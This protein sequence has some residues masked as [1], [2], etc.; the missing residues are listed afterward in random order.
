[1]NLCR[2]IAGSTNI[3][4]NK[5]SVKF[6]WE[7]HLIKDKVYVSTHWYS[8]LIYSAIL[9]HSRFKA[10]GRPRKGTL[11]M[12]LK[13]PVDL[14]KIKGRFWMTLGK[15]TQKQTLHRKATLLTVALQGYRCSVA[16]IW[17]RCSVALIWYRCSVALIWYRCSVALICKLLGC[18]SALSLLL[19]ENLLKGAVKQNIQRACIL[20]CTEMAFP[21]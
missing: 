18:S 4:L 9:S 17:Y 12:V 8:F 10:I 16:L 15:H 1:M 20:C 21:S 14:L 5:H 7:H 13:R 11:L 2:H 19:S 6:F 3:V